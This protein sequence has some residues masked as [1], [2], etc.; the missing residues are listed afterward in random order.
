LKAW[1][2]PQE[3]TEGGF[4]ASVLNK[5]ARKGSGVPEIIEVEV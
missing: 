3:I 4:E 1:D 5:P 2:L